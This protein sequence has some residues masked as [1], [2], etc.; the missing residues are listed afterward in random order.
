MGI[1][2]LKFTITFQPSST[3]KVF[4]VDFVLYYKDKTIGID[5]KSNHDSI[6]NGMSL[7]DKKFKPYKLLLIGEAGIPIETFLTMNIIDLFK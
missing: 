3:L 4:E 2:K 1:S 6:T 5:V 7:F